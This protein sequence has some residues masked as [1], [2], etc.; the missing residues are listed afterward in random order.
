MFQTKGDHTLPRGNLLGG[1]AIIN[2]RKRPWERKREKGMF[3]GFQ[4]GP[5]TGVPQSFQANNYLLE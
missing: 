2:D 5:P 1:E 3:F 4:I